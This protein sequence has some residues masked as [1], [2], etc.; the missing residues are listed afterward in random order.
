[1][2]AL[3]FGSVEMDAAEVGGAMA[4]LDQAL[5]AKVRALEHETTVCSHPTTFPKF[6]PTITGFFDA[7]CLE[8]QPKTG[9]PAPQTVVPWSTHWSTKAQ[10]ALKHWFCAFLHK[11]V[12][13]KLVLAPC[14]SSGT[15]TH[16]ALFS[17][18]YP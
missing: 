3:Q 15:G 16:L 5:L 4:G 9:R 8:C 17:G 10:C 7:V 18:G 6:A 11:I 14:D 2:Q 1:M 13:C 12:C